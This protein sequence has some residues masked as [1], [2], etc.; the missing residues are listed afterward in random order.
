M[1]PGSDTV[2]ATVKHATGRRFQ[3]L[4]RSHLR[5]GDTI[6]EIGGDLPCIDVALKREL[7]LRLIALDARRRLPHVPLGL[8]D[9]IVCADALAYR[10]VG[11][12]DVAL[13][14]EIPK[15]VADQNRLFVTVAGLV[16]P[17]GLVVL[18][19][20]TNDRSVPRLLR[21]LAATHGLVVVDH[22]RHG[23]GPAWVR[24]LTQWS[25]GLRRTIG[26]RSGFSI[27]LRTGVMPLVAR[28]RAPTAPD[29]LLMDARSAAGV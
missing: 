29:E 25:A 24:G 19:S 12:G 28:A 27:A 9:A 6:Y 21:E 17:G 1:R 7:R 3:R 18:H 5:P 20:R 13:W 15:D 2:P 26:A 16:R 10:G 11:D 4:L 22:E 23:H 8:Y 14:H